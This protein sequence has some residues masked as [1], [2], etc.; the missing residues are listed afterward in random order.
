MTGK[1]TPNPHVPRVYIKVYVFCTIYQNIGKKKL[2]SAVVTYGLR[3]QFPDL[4]KCPR[5]KVF[6]TVITITYLLLLEP[7]CYIFIKYIV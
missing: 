7:H 6:Y 4:T 2:I 1:K 5:R 3:K